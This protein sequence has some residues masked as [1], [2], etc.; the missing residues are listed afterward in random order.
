MK[1]IARKGFTLIEIVV[2]CVIMAALFI[3]CVTIILATYSSFSK[4]K[5]RYLIAQE[6]N[7][8]KEE[9][10]LYVTDDTSVTDNAP[11]SP[12]WHLPQD[13]SFPIRYA[14]ATGSSHTVTA[15][16][17]EGATMYYVVTDSPYQGRINKSVTITVDWTP[18]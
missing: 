18:K 9:L 4:D 12:A 5:A 13:T 16:L 14:L 3:T 2:A 15:N 1:I 10:K 11:G 7:N 6:A 17:P 8:L